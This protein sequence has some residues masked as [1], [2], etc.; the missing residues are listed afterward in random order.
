MKGRVTC[1]RPADASFAYCL[2][3]GPALGWLGLDP[4]NAIPEGDDHVVVAR[5]RDY[6]DVAPVE[7]TILSYGG[8]G[9]L[10]VEVDIIPV[11]DKPH[12]E[13]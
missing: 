8:H 9:E 2:W 10:D 3:C 6:S 4:T 11:Q 7:G 13:R 1:A 5:G 12:V